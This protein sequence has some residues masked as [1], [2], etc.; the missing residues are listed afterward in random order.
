MGEGGVRVG[1]PQI[2]TSISFYPYPI[3]AHESLK[4][5][6][7]RFQKCHLTSASFLPRDQVCFLTERQGLQGIKT[8]SANVTQLWPLPL[9]PWPLPQ[10]KFSWSSPGSHPHTAAKA[11]FLHIMPSYHFLAGNA[12]MANCCPP[13]SG[14]LPLPPQTILP[15]LSR[16]TT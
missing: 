2:S 14:C 3:Q 5:T 8:N 6:P 16:L 9:F 15:P 12:T 13:E 7:T 11:I 1:G 4:L 10:A